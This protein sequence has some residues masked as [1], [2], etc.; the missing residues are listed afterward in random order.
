[1]TWNWFSFA[2]LSTLLGISG[3]TGTEGVSAFSATAVTLRT[4]LPA[5]TD[6]VAGNCRRRNVLRYEQTTAQLNADERVLVNYLDA[7]SRLAANETVPVYHAAVQAAGTSVGEVPV[8]AKHSVISGSAAG[9]IANVLVD[10][11]T[12]HYRARRANELILQTDPAMQQLCAALRQVVGS[13]YVSLLDDEALELTSFYGDPIAARKAN[14]ERLTLILVLR[15]EEADQAAL[16]RHRAAAESYVR[17]MDELAKLHAQLAAQAKSGGSMKRK[18]AALAPEIAA[19]RDA[20]STL[21][22]RGS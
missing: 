5:V 12:K 11:A 13:D 10:A 17:V 19:L 20:V 22:T 8:I 16:D 21:Q 18:L 1:M 14:E 9:T 7:L 15:Q 6:D 4:A 2:V 3:C